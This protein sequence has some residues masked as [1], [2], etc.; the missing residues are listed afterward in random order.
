V[1]SGHLSDPRLLTVP[2]PA[3]HADIDEECVDLVPRVRDERFHWGRHLRWEADRQ[4]YNEAAVTEAIR[5]DPLMRTLRNEVREATNAM[6][7]TDPD[8]GIVLTRLGDAMA[9]MHKRARELGYRG[10]VPE[11]PKYTIVPAPHD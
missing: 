3:C 5:Y 8:L 11:V 10:P 4:P 7:I 9:R 1:T 6:N 2:C